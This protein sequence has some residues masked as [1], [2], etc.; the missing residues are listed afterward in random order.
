MI[1]LYTNSSLVSY[2]RISPNRNSPRN[3]SIDTISIHC[4]VGQV[5]VEDMGAWFAN[6]GAQASSN[7]GIGSDG[8]IGLFVSE[9]DRSWCTSSRDND[10]RAITIERA[11]DRTDP[12]AVNDQVYESLIKLLVDICKRNHIKQLLWKGDKNLIGQVDK[13]NMTVHRWFANKACPGDYLYNRHGDIARRVNEKLGV[14]SKSNQVAQKIAETKESDN[15]QI[16]WNYF[17]NKGLNEYAVAGLMGNIR[18]ESALSPINMQDSF[19]KKLGYTDASYTKAV[20]DGSYTN[21][22]RDGCGYGLAQWTFWSRKQGL[23]DFAKARRTSIGDLGMQ[24]DYLWTELQGYKY[25]CNT[26]ANA[27]SVRE[28]SNAVLTEF[29][30]PA[31]MGESVQNLRANY[32]QVYYNQFAKKE[33]VPCL[34]HIQVGAYSRKTNANKKLKTLEAAGFSGI[35]K[36]VKDVY[37]VQAGAFAVKTNAIAELEK[38]K[39]AG[40]KDAFITTEEA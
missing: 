19:E 25:L 29:E 28:A 20:D 13:Q 16:I 37:K 8:R 5:S 4:Y 30:K 1:K 40:F 10:N 38:L 35:I 12:Y 22:V 36:K 27:I 39:A 3:H 21:F 23:L 31:D 11:S 17:I 15:A 18:A 2:T 34:Y 6:I 26:L 32:G 9:C 7:Y 33:D 24:L 14:V